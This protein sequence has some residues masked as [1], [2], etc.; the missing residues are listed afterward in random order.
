MKRRDG[1]SES[2]NGFFATQMKEKADDH[3]NQ[4]INVY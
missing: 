1:K 4:A 2:Y 3:L